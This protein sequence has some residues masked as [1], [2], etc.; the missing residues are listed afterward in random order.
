M[1]PKERE[2]LLIARELIKLKF[3]N[4]KV[5]NNIKTSIRVN[6]S[7]SSAFYQFKNIIEKVCTDS[8]YIKNEQLKIVK[9]AL[10]GRKAN[11]AKELIISE[12]RRLENEYSERNYTIFATD[13]SGGTSS[14]GCG[15][16]NVTL[17]Q[18][19]LFSINFLTSSAFSELWAIAKA[20]DI[21]IEGNCK[22]IAIF[23]DSL[24]ACHLLEKHQSNNYIVA[25]IHSNLNEHN[26]TCNIIWTPGHMGI[27]MNEKAD[28]LAKFAT[29][30]GAPINPLLTPE[31]AIRQIESLLREEWN[32]RYKSLSQDKG[33]TFATFFPDIPKTPWY[34]N[35]SL[36]SKEIKIINRLITGHTYDKVYLHKIKIVNSNICDFC[37]TLDTY[38]HAIF[39][40]GRHNSIRDKYN[41]VKKHTNFK[42][43]YDNNDG[44]ALKELCSFINETQIEI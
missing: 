34:H 22:N 9:N 32:S 40:C 43:F 28:I 20:I 19:F 11:I 1:E 35:S 12:Y 27:Q 33:R 8:Y 29:D 4:K 37:H 30:V 36:N 5:Y 13:A 2:K 6:S 31:E 3:I 17:K 21:A 24:T 25:K 7:Y 15:V 41:A 10:V 44:A 39:A 26:M 23:T 42:E 38:N 18:E 14:M 16:Y